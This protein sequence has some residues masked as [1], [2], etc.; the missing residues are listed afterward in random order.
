M[1]SRLL[2]QALQTAQ[3]SRANHPEWGSF[4]HWTFVIQQNQLVAS[5][6]N[7]TGNAPPEYGYDPINDKLHSELVAY[8]K[9]RGLLI[10]SPWS[11]IN[12]RLNK[13]GS[14]KISAPCRICANWLPLVG[15]SKVW[16]TTPSG[17]ASQRL[18]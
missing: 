7:R 16:F 8:K 4:M 18:I 13:D 1:K 6:V 14:P 2:T 11:I 12:V 3:E 10:P 15:C 5:G 17:W 9:A